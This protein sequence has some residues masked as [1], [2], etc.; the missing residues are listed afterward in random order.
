MEDGAGGV[1]EEKAVPPT[2]TRS[3]SSPTPSVPSRE[4]FSERSDRLF[5]SAFVGLTDFLARI[6]PVKKM[7][8]E[9]YEKALR[10]RLSEIDLHKQR[11][12]D[13]MN[14]LDGGDASRRT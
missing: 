5:G 7:D 1:A 4:T 6:S 12:E 8:D 11:L 13:E 9:E 14:E 2:Y 3:I 10:S